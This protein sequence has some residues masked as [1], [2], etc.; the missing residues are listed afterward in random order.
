M[1]TLLSILWLG[2]AQAESSSSARSTINEWLYDVDE[3]TPHGRLQVAIQ[4]LESEAPRGT[5]VELGNSHP[6]IAYMLAD[7]VSRM[8]LTYT[9]LIPSPERNRLRKGDGVIR[10]FE[11]M[12]KTEKK[13]ALLLAKTLGLPKKLVAIRINSFNGIDI[14][15]EITYKN[16]GSTAREVITLARPYTPVFAEEARS[17]VGK[18]YQTK[19]L[20]P[21]K[22]PFS[23]MPFTNASF[24]MSNKDWEKGVGFRFENEEP[25]GTI[26]Y[27]TDKVMDG[28]RSLKFYNT[29][30]TMVFPNL[31]QSIPVG[32]TYKVRF[33][34][35]VQAKNAQVEYRQDSSATNISLHY[36]T[37]DGSVLKSET[38]ELRLGTYEWEQLII[39][40]FV[41]QDAQTVD[42]VI[43][44]SV[45][46]TIW[47]DGCSMIRID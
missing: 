30:D 24:E 39:D 5:L 2:S 8:A 26:S 21:T 33:Q 32:D 35:F 47:I 45:S 40:S 17:A 28:K 37:A 7:P 36:K 6:H 29:E 43:N 38:K 46:G 13:Q 9:L 27:D 18:K 16:Q 25:V 15:M 1:L 41:P 14:S 19:P 10:K 3:L 42:V 12:S 11:K 31:T 4:A 34:T 23:L 22:G 44:A 20:P